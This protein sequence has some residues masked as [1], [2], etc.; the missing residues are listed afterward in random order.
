MA[1]AVHETHSSQAPMEVSVVVCTNERTANAVMVS[2]SQELVL[3][4]PLRLFAEISI[5]PARFHSATTA[6]P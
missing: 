2:K 5:D 4:L 1:E 6:N 3:T